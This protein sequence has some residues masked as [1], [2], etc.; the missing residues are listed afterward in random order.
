[1][2]VTE[3]RQK[4]AEDQFIQE[5]DEAKQTLVTIEKVI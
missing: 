5:A 3:K 2:E 1:M 4:E